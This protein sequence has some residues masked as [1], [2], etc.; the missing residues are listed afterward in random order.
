MTNPMDALLSLQTALDADTVHMRACDIHPDLKVLLD[1][2]AGEPRLTYATVAAGIVQSLAIFIPAEPVGDV[3]CFAVGCAVIESMRGRGLAKET[4][5]KAMDEMLKGLKRNGILEFYV[6]AVVATSNVA[7]N[8]L[9][10]TSLSECPSA[11]TDA[12]SGKAVFQYLK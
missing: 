1:H 6:E 2:P 8:R 3:P 10:R 11:G 9:A 7:S 12:I 5:R 4:L